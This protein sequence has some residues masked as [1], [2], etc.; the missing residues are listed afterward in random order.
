M[1]ESITYSAIQLMHADARSPE[2]LLNEHLTL[3]ESL[4]PNQVLV[5]MIYSAINPSDFMMMRNKYVI[6]KSVPAVLGTVGVGFVV[7]AGTAM[8]S[9]WL[10]GKR[11]AC[12]GNYTGDGTWGQYVVTLNSAVLPLQNHISNKVGANL[13]SNP[14][15]ALAIIDVLKEKHARVVLQSAASSDI[16][17][18]I[19]HASRKNNIQM[20]NIVRNQVQVELLTSKFGF[21]TLNSTSPTFENDLEEVARRFGPTIFLD[22]VSGELT[23]QAAKALAPGGQ[24]ILY[25]ILSNENPVIDQNLF[26]Q[27]DL[28]LETFSI[29]H[30][31]SN[32]SLPKLVYH[33]IQLQDFG[34]K[35]TGKEVLG[36][37][38]LHQLFNE[39]PEFEKNS[40]KHKYL[41]DPFLAK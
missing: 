3:P 30:W 28:R 27:K 15:T 19:Q 37:V 41:L 1:M 4:M 8:R 18:L 39:W 33:A 32:L 11:V 24:V 26:S 23:S 6:E 35:Y 34:Q 17:Q 2:L 14:N 29:M 36:F 10:L 13:L 38:G 22:A 9:R 20:I 12:S 40:Q 5:K 21:P 16:G 7:S 25:G 31:L